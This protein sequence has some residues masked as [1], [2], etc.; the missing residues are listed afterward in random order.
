MQSIDADARK[1]PKIRINFVVPR[2]SGL[3]RISDLKFFL[4]NLV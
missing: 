3:G 2:R 1:K 4:T